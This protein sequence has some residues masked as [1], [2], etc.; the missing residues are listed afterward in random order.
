MTEPRQN[1]DCFLR[2]FESAGVVPSGT[3]IFPT[4]AR[5][6]RALT[7][8]EDGSA[9]LVSPPP[10]PC[11]ITSLTVGLLPENCR[12]TPYLATLSRQSTL[13]GAKH[14]GGYRAVGGHPYPCCRVP[15]KGDLPSV[16]PPV[17]PLMVA[18]CFRLPG[19]SLFVALGAPTVPGSMTGHSP[20]VS[21]RHI[22]DATTTT[23][24]IFR[25]I[26]C[27]PVLECQTGDISPFGGRMLTRGPDSSEEA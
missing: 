4:R 12:D 21:F 13:V 25:E 19:G 20:P 24:L 1:R 8:K 18:F 11:S 17:L 26:R 16:T 22:G 6:N 7:E 27:P 10:Q 14:L 23:A 9:G 3:P 15:L 5:Q 2:P